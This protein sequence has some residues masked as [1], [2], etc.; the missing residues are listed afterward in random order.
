M[1]DETPLDFVRRLCYLQIMRMG[2][3]QFIVPSPYHLFHLP[4][5]RR[6]RYLFDVALRKVNC[7]CGVR[8]FAGTTSLMLIF[9]AKINE[10]EPS[11]HF[12]IFKMEMRATE[13]RFGIENGFSVP[14][15]LGDGGWQHAFRIRF[16]SPA[17]ERKEKM[18]INRW[19]LHTNPSHCLPSSR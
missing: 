7:E 8:L 1:A 13:N 9:V 5:V 15:T 10:W 19:M 16:K 17:G 18:V 12:W 14:E 3:S 4:I 6:S 2:V 11:Q